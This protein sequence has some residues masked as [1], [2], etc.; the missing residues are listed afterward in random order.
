MPPTQR[1]AWSDVTTAPT[2]PHRGRGAGARRPRADQRHRRA[3][4]PHASA[5][6]SGPTSSPASTRSS[7]PLVAVILVIGPIQDATFALDP[8]GERGHRHLPGGAAPS[9]RS[10]SSRCRTRPRRACVRDGDVARDRDRGGGARRPARAAGRRPDPVRRRRAHRD[11]LEVDESLLTGESD[12]INKADGDEVLSG[13]FVVAGSGR[14]QATKVGPDSYAAKL[15]KEAR[16]FQL[17][18]SE[19]MDGINTILRIVTWVLIPVSALLLWSQ[20]RDHELDTALRSTVAGVVG[21]GARGPRAAHQRRVH[22]RGGHAGSPPGAGA[23]AARGRG[24]G[25]GRRRVPRQDGHAHRGR[26]SCSTSSSRSTAA[27]TAR[28]GSARRARRRREPQR[29]RASRSRRS[30]RRPTVDAHR[31]GAVL[32]GPQVERGDASTGTGSWVMGAPEM[33]L[34][35][36]VVAGT[37]ARRRAR[38]R[39]GGARS[40]WRTPTRRSP[41]RRCPPGSSRWRW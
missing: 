39:A 40:C 22:G 18:R 26:R 5:R 38:R 7:A 8:R 2:R 34:T 23:G 41:A 9:G 30:S 4:Q 14:F 32:V 36:D 35:D 15:A 33:V 12:P 16:R 10:T 17:T 19:L 31:R 29:H 11:G 6:S 28:H 24:P 27:T 3:H 13:S 1:R 21:D 20:L 25:A 37:G